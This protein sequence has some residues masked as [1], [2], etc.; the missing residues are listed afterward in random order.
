MSQINKWKH[1]SWK[2]VVAGIFIPLLAALPWSVEI[3]IEPVPEIQ[4]IF[5][6]YDG[7]SFVWI[8]FAFCYL[9]YFALRER[10]RLFYNIFAYTS[11]AAYLMAFALVLLIGDGYHPV[12]CIGFIYDFFGWNLSCNVENFLLIFIVNLFLISLFVFWKHINPSD[13]RSDCY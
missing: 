10:A 7:Y 13:S 8:W 5:L 1:I 9:V 6:P 4:K 2:D 11:F 12:F 3:L